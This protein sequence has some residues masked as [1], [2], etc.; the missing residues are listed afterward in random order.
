MKLI[1]FLFFTLAL[2]LL[3]TCSFNKSK[4]SIIGNWYFFDKDMNYKELYIDNSYIT[5]CDEKLMTYTYKYTLVDDSLFI[6]TDDH[7]T[8]RIITKNEKGN[9]LMQFDSN[10]YELRKIPDLRTDF[11]DAERKGKEGYKKFLEG[12]QKRSEREHRI[13]QGSEK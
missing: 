11:Y 2:G 6:N 4:S 12:F 7:I 3:N 10:Y 8:K 9:L 5:L 13:F 1:N